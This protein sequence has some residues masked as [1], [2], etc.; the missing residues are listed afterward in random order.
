MFSLC[1]SLHTS[2]TISSFIANL[3]VMFIC[4]VEQKKTYHLDLQIATL[5][6]LKKIVFSRVDYLDWLENFHQLTWVQWFKDKLLVEFLLQ[7][8]MLLC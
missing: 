8:Q 4:F 5:H 1:V 6:D 7:Q 2:N 3:M